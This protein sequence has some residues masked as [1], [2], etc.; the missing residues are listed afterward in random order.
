MLAHGKW[1]SAMPSLQQ[2]LNNHLATLEL[3]AHWPPG[4]R[5]LEAAQ[6]AVRDFDARIIAQHL[7][8]ADPGRMPNGRL[9]V[10]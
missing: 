8:P 2:L 9:K 1:R 4:N 7:T 6:A 10:Y 3:P 5:E